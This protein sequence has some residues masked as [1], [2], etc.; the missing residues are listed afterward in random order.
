MKLGAGVDVSNVNRT[1]EVVAQAPSQSRRA[2]SRLEAARSGGVWGFASLRCG[3]STSELGS[4]GGK[5]KDKLG[6]SKPVSTQ[7][8]DVSPIIMPPLP[9]NSLVLP[10]PPSPPHS[11]VYSCKLQTAL[12]L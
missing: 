4:L 11:R 10:P 7:T 1:F 12:P 3:T 8:A 9:Q 2:V 5:K 6:G